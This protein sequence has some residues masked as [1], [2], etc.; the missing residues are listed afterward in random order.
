M[1][2]QICGRAFLSSSV[3]S[4]HF[5]R[6]NNVIWGAFFHM[7][8]V[9]VVCKVPLTEIYWSIIDWHKRNFSSSGS[10]CQMSAHDSDRLPCPWPLFAHLNCFCLLML[11]LHTNIYIYMFVE[12]QSLLFN[13]LY[14]V[15]VIWNFIESINLN[16]DGCV[17]PNCET[18][19]FKKQHDLSVYLNIHI[20]C[21]NNLIK[22]LIIM[23][24][25]LW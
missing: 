3:S 14:Y 6:W 1:Q 22:E 4:G 10:H 24:H 5:S 17:G 19:W 20:L 18:K 12:S 15:D 11:S 16:Q 23:L 21:I 9:R 13:M 8:A 7:S 25:Q 2:V